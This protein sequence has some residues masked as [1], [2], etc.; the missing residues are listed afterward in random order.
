VS[1][2]FKNRLARV[3]SVALGALALASVPARATPDFTHVLDANLLGLRVSNVGSFGFDAPI[4]QSGLEF[5]RGSGKS[6]LFAGGLWLGA[7]VAGETR[8]TLAEYSFEFG[9]G[10]LL[11]PFAPDRPEYHVYVVSAADTAGSAEWMANAAPLGAP[12][13]EDGLAPGVIGDKTLWCVYN[14]ARASLHTNGGGGSPPL[15][16]EVRQTAWAYHGSALRDHTAFLRFEIFNK[17]ANTL[18]SAYVTL[19]ADPDLGSA[20]DDNIASDPVLDMGYVYNNDDDDGVYGAAP[21]AL[22]FVLMKGP[23]PTS[24]VSPLHVSVA[25]MYIGGTDPDTT[26]QSWRL[27]KGL[28]QDGSPWINPLTSQ[29]TPFVFTGDP[30]AGTGWLD[31]FVT[32]KRFLISAGPFTMAPGDS[33]DIELAIVIGQGAD[34][35]ESVSILHN[36]AAKLLELGG[37]DPPDPPPPPVPSNELSLSAP[38]GVTLGPLLF[39]VTA[40]SGE[41]WGLDVYDVAGR[42]V[43]RVANGT[44]D[45]FQGYEIWNLTTKTGKARPGVYYVT[46]HT[47]TQRATKRVI[48]LHP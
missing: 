34:R 30:V 20:G 15:G 27:I 19:W 32:D 16:V 1:I 36:Y 2:P 31:P 37:V 4:G 10:P 21:P 40:P 38:I 18:D 7:K 26:E 43:D 46:L 39:G 9:P 8:V 22:G 3:A 33:Q 24:S 12:T 14:D 35:L 47:D 44:G 6:A 29:T 48:V 5:P 45:G 41:A 13:T 25:N 11:G 42:H 28:K 23:T 17:G